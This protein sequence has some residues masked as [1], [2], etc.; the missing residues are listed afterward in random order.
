MNIIEQSL[1]DPDRL[2]FIEDLVLLGV[3]WSE[4]SRRIE[5]KYNIKATTKQIQNAYDKRIIRR[6]MGL[7]QDN[8]LKDQYN[9]EIRR[10]IEKLQKQTEE[11]D[12]LWEEAKKQGVK[13]AGVMLGIANETRRRVEMIEKI[14]GNLNAPKE[15]TNNFVQVN[16]SNMKEFQKYLVQLEKAGFIR[17]KRKYPWED[18]GDNMAVEVEYEATNE[19]DKEEE[20]EIENDRD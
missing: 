7:M 16:L 9:L 4:I 2:A 3:N 14:L 12:L 17:K 6:E 11:L 10:L 5:Q 15:Q 18:G 20:V 1:L 19:E 8:R 13:N